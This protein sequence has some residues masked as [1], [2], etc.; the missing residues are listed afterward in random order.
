MLTLLFFACLLVPN[1]G[2]TDGVIKITNGSL[3][4]SSAAGG[5]IVVNSMDVLAEVA[6]ITASLQVI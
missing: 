2:E 6:R 5:S 1:L 3:E 4:I